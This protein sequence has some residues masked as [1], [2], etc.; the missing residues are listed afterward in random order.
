MIIILRDS[1]YVD[2]A[3]NVSLMIFT[4]ILVQLFSHLIFFPDVAKK[5]FL[6]S[7]K[8]P[9]NNSFLFSDAKNMTD[10]SMIFSGKLLRYICLYQI[11]LI[12]FDKNRFSC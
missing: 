4:L 7:S 11:I 9:K 6:L 12:K 1:L 10:R 3:Q 2:T 5:V 8:K